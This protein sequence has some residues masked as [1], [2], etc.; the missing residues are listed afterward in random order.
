MIA[1]VVEHG[2]GALSK[3]F[4]VTVRLLSACPVLPSQAGGHGE[5]TSQLPEHS[6]SGMVCSCVAF[7][8]RAACAA[9]TTE[10]QP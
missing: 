5:H 10:E 6:M 3:S 9:G 7:P 2:L 1:D 4:T 8:G